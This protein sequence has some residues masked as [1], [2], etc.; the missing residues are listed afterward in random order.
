[1][2]KGEKINSIT[3]LVGA[4]LSL[5]AW[6]LLV[7]FSSLTGDTLKIISCTIYGFTLFILYLSST[8]YHSFKGKAKRVF[9]FF[10]HSSIFLLIAGTYTPPALVII[11]GTMGWV[12]IGLVWGFAVVGIIFKSI[13][14]DKFDLLSTFFYLLCGWTILIDFKN[15]YQKFP[16][17]GFVWLVIGGALYTI[18]AFFYAVDRIPRNHEIWHFFVLFASTAHFFSIFFYVI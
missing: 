7:V 5:V 4:S 10:D 9:R 1:M 2:Y 16:T 12:I 13:W 14:I 15:F 18:G 3:H 8:L 11:Q 17:G 6:T